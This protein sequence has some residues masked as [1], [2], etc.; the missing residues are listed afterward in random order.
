METM[1]TGFGYTIVWCDDYNVVVASGGR[2]GDPVTIVEP[3]TVVMG[4]GLTVTREWTTVDLPETDCD[5][6]N[7]FS[8]CGCGS[9]TRYTH[10]VL[11]E[12][13]YGDHALVTVV[14]TDGTWFEY[15][16]VASVSRGYPA[17]LE[18]PEEDGEV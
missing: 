9:G 8:G 3:T 10:Y 2:R 5:G 12:D 11:L 16:H 13:D 17:H 4:R 1:E 15:E 18:I 7:H 14:R 6:F